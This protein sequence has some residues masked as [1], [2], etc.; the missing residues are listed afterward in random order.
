MKTPTYLIL[1]G[2][3]LAATWA[4]SQGTLVLDQYSSLDE[5]TMAGSGTP[6]QW[7]ATPFGQSFTPS[8]SAIDYIKLN[9]SD[10]FTGNGLGAT[11]YVVLHS[12]SI[13]GPVLGTTESVYLADS[14][15]TISTF[16][17]ASTIALTAGTAYYAEIL[18]QSGS[19]DW[20]IITDGYNYTGGSLI[21][22]GSGHFGG[23]GGSDAWFQEGIVVIPEPS[24]VWLLLVGCGML[25]YVR[26]RQNCRQQV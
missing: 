23:P 13:G 18:I 8:L 12:D 17:F 9:L 5:R 7:F 11:I 1:S 14:S 15:A 19:D 6:I 10:H 22:G 16:L 4:H 24:S 3:L 26:S 25:L 2:L 20:D 21:V